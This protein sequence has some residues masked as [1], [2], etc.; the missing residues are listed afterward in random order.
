MRTRPAAL[1]A[2]EAIGPVSIVAGFAV[3]EHTRQTT[4]MVVSVFVAPGV[5]DVTEDAG[6]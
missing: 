5:A 2:T 4:R 1:D 6:Y 3:E